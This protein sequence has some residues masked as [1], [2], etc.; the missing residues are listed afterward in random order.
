MVPACIP[1]PTRHAQVPAIFCD[2]PI[3][4]CPAPAQMFFAQRPPP[5]LATPESLTKP[6]SLIAHVWHLGFSQWDGAPC[7]RYAVWLGRLRDRRRGH[8]NEGRA[9]DDV[10]P[11][12]EPGSRVSIPDVLGGAGRRVRAYGV[13]ADPVLRAVR[14]P[15]G[16]VPRPGAR[17]P[18]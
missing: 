18:E 17:R 5:R 6:I 10:D 1:G 7:G 15:A 2:S 12:D 3:W 11:P 4:L 8:A 16:P 9:C 13:G 14:D